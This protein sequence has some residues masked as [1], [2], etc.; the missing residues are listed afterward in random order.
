MHPLTPLR[1]MSYMLIALGLINWRYQ[2][3]ES[4]GARN[5][6]IIIAIGAILVALL[7][8]PM[9]QKIFSHRMVKVISWMVVSGAVLFAILN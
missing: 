8:L 4:T 6:L 2:S 3:A 1:W 5:S 9:T 7:F